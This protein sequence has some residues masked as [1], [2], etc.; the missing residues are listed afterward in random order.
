MRI[1]RPLSVCVT[2]LCACCVMLQAQNL[3]FAH[4]TRANSGLCYDGVKTLFEDSRGNVWIGTH[5]GLSRYDGRDFTCFGKDRLGVDSDFV[6][7]LAEDQDGHIYV[8]TDA[9]ICR[10]YARTND[11]RSFRPDI[12][13][14]RIYAMERDAEGVLWIGHRGKGLYSKQGNRLVLAPGTEKLESV[15]RIAPSVS[16]KLYLAAY[17]DDIYSY[18]GSEVRPICDGFFK[19][20]NVEGLVLDR[21]TDG[22]ALYVA[23]K[24]SGLCRVDPNTGEVTV[25]YDIPEGQRPVGISSDGY[26]I[27]LSTTDG[28]V[29]Y[30]IQG[31]GISVYNTQ[32]GNP[33][34]LSADY[35]TAVCRDRSGG[36]WVGT[37][38]DGVNY[39]DPDQERFHPYWQL[40]SGERLEGCGVKGFAE[41]ERGNVWVATEKMGLL[42]LDAGKRLEKAG[43]R[44]IPDNLTAVCADHSDLWVGTHQGLFHVYQ[45]GD[46]EWEWY[47]HFGEADQE[48]ENRVVSLFR[49]ARGELYVGTPV[50][51][52]QYDRKRDRFVPIPELSG[53][54]VENMVE[55][56]HGNLWLASYSQGA[57]RY[58]PDK[59]KIEK[60]YSVHAGV[61][62]VH[63]MTSSMALDVRGGL[64]VIGFSSGF[65]RYDNEADNFVRICR[66][67]LPDLPTDLFLSAL[68]D[69][70]GR[71]WMS[72]DAG[73]VLYDTDAGGV[74]V[75]S[76]KDGL[77]PC[78]FLKGA[79]RLSS[80]SF[81]FAQADGFVSLNPGEFD[82]PAPSV[83]SA[84]EPGL[85]PLTTALLAIGTILLAI[86]ISI[87]FYRWAMAAARRQEEDRNKAKDA[88]LYNDRLSFFANVIHEIKTPL[89]L[90][91]TPLQNLISAGDA[92]EEQLADL[93]IINNST[94]YLD[95]LVK[96]LL[97]FVRMEEHGFV[98]NLKNTD[99][100]ENLSF[101]CY[102]F[103]ETAKNANVRLSFSAT[104][105]HI[106]T[107]VDPKAISKIFNNLI[108][109][110]VKYSDSYLDIRAVQKGDK[111][112]VHFV[113]DGP[114]I[115]SDKRES[116]F[117]PFVRY[118]VGGR[119]YQQSFGIGL[120][121]ARTLTE[122]HEGT[123]ILSPRTDVTEFILTLPV[124]EAMEASQEESPEEMPAQASSLP[125]LLIVEDNADLSSYLRR[126]L[127]QDYKV[128]AVPSAE[129]ALEVL[130]QESVDLLL[131]DIGL[132]NMSGVELC[133]IV[134][135]DK[136]ISHIPIIVISAISSTET[137]IKCMENGATLYIEK[138]F[139]QDYL[140][141]CIKGV[142]DKRR[143][144][145]EAWRGI[146]QVPH[147]E[148]Q[149]RDE[150]FI[151]RLDQLIAEN[152]GDASFSNR[153][154]EEALFISRSSL[155]RRVKELLG[156][157]PND[158]V[159][160]K[161]LAAAAEMLRAGRVR[162]NEV[163][164][165][166]GFNSP[167]YFAKCFRKEFGVLP[168]EYMNQNQ[169]P[170][171]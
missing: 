66:E 109:N 78:E 124:R 67:N 24:R 3:R 98:L 106:V 126:K 69:T 52:L 82:S 135:R 144:Q 108:H 120:A 163:A 89:T 87:V 123:L 32:P 72:S 68:S 122:L 160:K 156:T 63:E 114:G 99:V 54:T 169:Q 27:W 14:A 11:F 31:G 88:Q 105:E 96:E 38:S 61:P 58:S 29:C 155:N 22:E 48:I 148:L 10:Y 119:E 134:S 146:P 94:E 76:Q 116:I 152:L 73:L 86:F 91:R 104:P 165:A 9:G 62:P 39:S 13:H 136:E 101:I 74:E 47:K 49:S 85:S 166:V 140:E 167:S 103:T 42:R 40:S 30:D 139:S 33:F 19:A 150:D 15:Y 60:N 129:K 2:L 23:S 20:D 1:G 46:V 34:S 7:S 4:F 5:M 26:S 35:V 127:R 164:Y 44:N 130:R 149:N 147:V 16:G 162:V 79:L 131:T 117:L 170:E 107:A 6:S 59:Q 112:E 51:V 168:A 145:K 64:W 92:S 161:R 110:G 95:Q 133:R 55:D 81:L 90:I 158:Y 37:A 43:F 84:R 118:S 80:G 159:Q 97:E 8:G 56:G 141:A 65:Y 100:A 153:Q 50:G 171:T 138:P 57:F 125:L 132:K 111:V 143:V 115:P 154:I 12:L 113:N 151:R 45:E 18:D 93:Q 28:L 83:A 75:F 25:L 157:T 102:N 70:K 17:C 21:V 121:Q 137:K 53:I 71:L 41:D 77:L 128:I 142:L 36:L